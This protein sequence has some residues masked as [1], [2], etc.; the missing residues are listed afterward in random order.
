MRSPAEL[1]EV[2]RAQGLKIT[3]Q[4]QV[5]FSLLHDTDQHPT[6]EMLFAAASDRMP[7]I[8]LRTVY[9]TLTELTSMGEVRQL[10]FGSGPARFDPN[11][12]D[13]HHV[14]CRTCGAIRDVD[15][16]GVDRLEP[17][18]AESLGGFEPDAVSIVFHGRCAECARASVAAAARTTTTT[19]TSTTPNTPTGGA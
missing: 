14:R 12:S 9:Q 11:G 4:R 3:P 8:S 10:A 7:G 1:T 2:F 6:A 16:G 15:V 18:D 13:H 19:T 5:L 17:L